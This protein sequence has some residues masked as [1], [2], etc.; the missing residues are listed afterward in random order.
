MDLKNFK[1]F[2][3][4][5]MFYFILCLKIFFNPYFSSLVS[6]RKKKTA[7]NF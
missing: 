3:Q 2:E 4:C 7:E 1:I 5:C 6:H